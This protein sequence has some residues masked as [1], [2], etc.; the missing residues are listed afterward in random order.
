[1]DIPKVS[2]SPLHKNWAIKLPVV[3]KEAAA[4]CRRHWRENTYT[5][6]TG[7]RTDFK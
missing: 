2:I 3:E 4:S 6:P 5:T 1:M 7:C